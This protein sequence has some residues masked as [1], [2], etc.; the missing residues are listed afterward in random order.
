MAILRCLALIDGEGKAVKNYHRFAVKPQIAKRKWSP[1]EG[2]ITLNE[3]FLGAPLLILSTT[4][5][6]EKSPPAQDRPANKRN[7]Q[8]DT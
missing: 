4:T 2:S 8:V 6:K 1:V 7:Q 5:K 3:T